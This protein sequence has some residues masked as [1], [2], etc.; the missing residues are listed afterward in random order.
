[1]KI[2]RKLEI[3]LIVGLLIFAAIFFVIPKFAPKPEQPNVL[4]IIVDTLRS[5][6]VGCYG[7]D[8]IKT[9]NI[10]NFAKKGT[11]FK[12]TISQ[13]PL[14][15]ASHASFL[16]STYPQ[17]NNVRDNGAAR[18]DES[19]IT[20]A[21]ALQ[22][23]GYATAAFVSTM[24]LDS[25]HGLNQG[26]ETY[27]DTVEKASKDRVLD[28]MDAERTGEKVTDSAIN[29]LKD[30]GNK[31]FFLWAHYYDPHTVYNPPSPYKEIYKDN[32]YDG[33]IAFADMQ[34]GRLLSF[35]KGMKLER[36]L[37]I[38]FASDHGEG[39]G[40]HGESSH[41]VF[42]YDTTLKVPLIFSYPGV[43]PEGKV[44]ESQVRL[45]DIMPTVLDF[46]HIEK[47]KEIQGKSLVRI[48]KGKS[49][50]KDLPA[51][52]ESLY[53][54]FHYNWSPLQAFRMGEWKYIKSS[55]PE[56][57]NIKRDPHELVNLIDEEA[58]LSM[59][60][61]KKLTDLLSKTT[62][63]EA[64]DTSLEIDDETRQQLMSLGYVQGTVDYGSKEP[65]PIEMIQVMENLNLAS[66]LANTGQIE[67]AIEMFDEI[68]KK[69]PNN[70][71]AHVS[72]AQCYKSL[73][74]Y[75]EAM[76]HFKVALSFNDDEAAAHDGL[77]NIFKDM[78]KVKEATEEFAKAL[79]LDPENPLI[80]NNMGWC[81]QQK[82]DFDKAIEYYDKALAMDN[83]IATAHANKGICYRVKGDLDKATEELN[84]AITQ[85]P[86]L[87]FAYAE[88]G[89]VWAIKGDLDKAIRYCEKAVEVD[90]KSI[91]GYNNMAVC[92]MRKKEYAK[93]LEN[94]QKALEIAPWNTLVYTNIAQAYL[95]LGQP[96]KAKEALEKALQL[97][98]NDQKVRQMLQRLT[99]LLAQ[100]SPI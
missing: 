41:A 72:I 91:D 62:S 65:V 28:L 21:E 42:V 59:E 99:Q 80:I 52:S 95:A 17:Y 12:N 16:T 14:T 9:P 44:V 86:E 40:E 53:A 75:E 69:D 23:E 25:K 96:L 97:N 63:E 77:G 3:L 64:K 38:I 60:L 4:L 57:Y 8:R 83:E 81:Y 36:D 5:D 35:I 79:E 47:N 74:K 54:K 19:A 46:L 7:Y 32:L 92:Y 33:E 93:A 20:L 66:S 98:P 48:I 94:Y 30:N 71:R 26:F 55:K 89:A 1:M 100:Q 27:D 70:L 18:L 34:I 39:L 82:E 31:K 43:I 90:P 29:W 13:V 87:A 24:V 73:G 45:L 6:H 37:F 68:L 67:K 51:Y 78:G 85:D 2:I 11:M 22:E 76:K 50:S 49:R 58:D 88:L 15:L 61:D 56:L 10:D 84:I